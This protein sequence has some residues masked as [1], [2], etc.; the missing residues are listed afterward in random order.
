MDAERLDRQIA[1]FHRLLGE[2][3]QDL[4]VHEQTK[5]L[6]QDQVKQHHVI[7][8]DGEKNTYGR[9]LYLLKS[10]DPYQQ[11]LSELQKLQ[12]EILRV[13]GLETIPRALLLPLVLEDVIHV[14][15][16][17]LTYFS[18]R[19]RPRSFVLERID[20]ALETTRMNYRTF[21]Q[22]G[23][24]ED[25]RTQDI[26]EEIRYHEG[27]REWVRHHPEPDYRVRVK[28][29]R[30]RLYVYQTGAKPKLCDTR[31]HGVL[32]VGPNITLTD[33]Y[34]MRQ[35]RSDKVSLEPLWHYG[36]TYVFPEKEWQGA[37]EKA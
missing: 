14:R 24:I 12:S 7:G 30:I 16:H 23:G 33:R 4:V 35:G 1:Y 34:E 10:L 26:G 3:L 36:V 27:V 22:Q 25:K 5:W 20:K 28:Q 13:F 15:L 31:L 29:E 17:H 19:S 8:R 21:A 2:M 9:A 32:L 11:R 6:E 18:S 37:K